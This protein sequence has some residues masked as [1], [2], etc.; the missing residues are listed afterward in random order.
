MYFRA[1]SLALS[2]CFWKA[3]LEAMSVAC[4]ERRLARRRSKLRYKEVGGVDRRAYK[5]RDIYVHPINGALHFNHTGTKLHVGL[6][7][8]KR[9]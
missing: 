4:W 9:S 2:A 3:W 5:V 7:K 6:K 8:K 1:A